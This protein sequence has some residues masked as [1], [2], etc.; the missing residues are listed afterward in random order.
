MNIRL[1]E[2]YRWLSRK[3]IEDL[4]RILS[5]LPARHLESLETI[6]AVESLG[7]GILATASYYGD[8][9][10]ITLSSAYFELPYGE[11][12]STLIHELGH[13]YYDFLEENMGDK[14]RTLLVWGAC[15]KE[16]VEH[17]PR[18]QWM[19]LGL[20]DLREDKWEELRLANP[21]NRAFRDKYTYIT[22]FKHGHLQCGE[23][24][25]PAETRIPENDQVTHGFN[26]DWA[27]YSPME[28]I[29]DAYALFAVGKDYFIEC[30]QGNEVIKAKLA[31][32][33]AHFANGNHADVR[34]VT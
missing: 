19:D 9:K 15:R 8:G 31:F 32:T 27:H 12:E 26:Y 24:V 34:L 17:L 14:S 22:M 3:E 13:T 23:W 5:R 33:Q 10:D 2:T 28:E 1:I 29:A 21:N 4:E 30:A 25:C 7:R 6:E 11:R 16:D 18:V 20:W